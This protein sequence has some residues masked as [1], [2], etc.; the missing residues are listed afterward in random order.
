MSGR[1][2]REA[3]AVVALAAAFVVAAAFLV[4]AGCSAAQAVCAHDW[5]DRAISSPGWMRDEQTPQVVAYL[6]VIGTRPL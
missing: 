3:R 6:A 2:G 4:A 5:P 1:A